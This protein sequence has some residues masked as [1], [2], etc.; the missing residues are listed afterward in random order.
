MLI[1]WGFSNATNP[2]PT[3]ESAYMRPLEIHRHSFARGIPFHC[4]SH[5]MSNYIELIK[6]CKRKKLIERARARERER[7]FQ[8]PMGNQ[9]CYLGGDLWVFSLLNEV[10]IWDHYS[11]K[12]CLNHGS[13]CAHKEQQLPAIKSIRPVY[14][15]LTWFYIYDWVTAWIWFTGKIMMCKTLWFKANKV[16]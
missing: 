5:T 2:P 6:Q 7:F 11:I 1:S 12:P 13:R 16:R 8:F 14:F 10:V 9:S 3:R 4:W 15:D